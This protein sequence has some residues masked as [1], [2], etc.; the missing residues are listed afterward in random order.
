MNFKPLGAILAA[1]CTLWAA[2]EGCSFHKEPDGLAMTSTQ[3]NIALSTEPR[4]QVYAAFDRNTADIYISDLPESVLETPGDLLRQQG[5][6]V[7]VHMFLEPKAG[8]TPIDTTACSFTVRQLV[9]GGGEAGL[10]GGGGFLFMKGRAGDQIFT[11]NF[12]N[13]TLRLTAATAG[14]V[15]RL[16]PSEMTGKFSATRADQKARTIGQ[17]F[18]ETIAKLKAIQTVNPA[19]AEE[20]RKRRGRS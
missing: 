2:S 10:Y 15:D 7:H 8:E 3:A 11:G 18:G 1:G 12:Q 16:G 14:F 9:L 6:L 13:A 4:T 19:S 17:R 20:S 5:T